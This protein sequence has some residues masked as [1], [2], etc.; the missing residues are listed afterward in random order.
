MSAPRKGSQL[1]TPEP[2][3]SPEVQH[4]VALER[5][6]GAIESRVDSGFERMTAALNGLTAQV[7]AQNG[8]VGANSEKISALSIAEASRTAEER[9]R[10]S[11][12]SR[13]FMLIGASGT[14]FVIG[15][16]I[17]DLIIASVTGQ[18]S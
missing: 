10:T 13:D 18:P 15:R 16:T 8:R 14:V 4:A 9:G 3:I 6:L 11:L 2:G 5:R 7:Q 12:R 1:P 17:F